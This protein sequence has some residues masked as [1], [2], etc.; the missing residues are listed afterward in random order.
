V[1][2]ELRRRSSAAQDWKFAAHGR[3]S[4]RLARKVIREFYP[5]VAAVLGQGAPGFDMAGDPHHPETIA[6]ARV[7]VGARLQFGPARKPHDR[8]KRPICRQFDSD[9]P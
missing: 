3:K 1:G 2:G 7:A 8:H 4:Q 6:T 9:S 5:I